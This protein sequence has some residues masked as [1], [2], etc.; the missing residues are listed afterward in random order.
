MANFAINSFHVLA[1]GLYGANDPEQV[2]T[3]RWQVGGT[4]FTAFIG[5]FGMRAS[6][7]VEPKVPDGLF[8]AIEAAILAEP[9]GRDAHW[10]R[11][12]A[13]NLNGQMTFEALLDNEPWARGLASLRDAPWTRCDGYYSIRNF[14]LLRAV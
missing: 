1:A 13:A 6:T 9:L 12:F 2:T 8:N 4:R 11:A 3:E 14:I 10:V 7:G 5:N